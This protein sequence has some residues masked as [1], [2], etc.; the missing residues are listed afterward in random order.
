MIGHHLRSSRRAIVGG[1]WQA[2]LPRQSPRVLVT[3]VQI[4]VG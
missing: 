4:S 3:E 2:Q 1:N